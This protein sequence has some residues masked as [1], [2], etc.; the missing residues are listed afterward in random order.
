VDPGCVGVAALAG[1]TLTIAARVGETR[2]IDNRLL[3][4]AT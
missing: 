1:P 2:L 4:G 3:K